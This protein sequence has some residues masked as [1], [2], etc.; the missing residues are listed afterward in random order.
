MAISY[1]S[2]GSWDRTEAWLRGLLDSDIFA[3]LDLYGQ[4]GADA[5]AADTPKDTGVTAAAWEYEIREIRDGYSLTWI[6]RETASDNLVLMLIYGHGTGTGGY[7]Q[8][9]DFVTPAMEPI[10]EAIADDA[11]KAVLSI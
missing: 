3:L 8:G 1:T 2:E 4:I 5:L 6:N 9:Y 11:A 7:V 10:F